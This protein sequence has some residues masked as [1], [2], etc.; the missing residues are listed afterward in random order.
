[1]SRTNNTLFAVLGLLM[2]GPCSGYDIRK[3]FNGSLRY[4][5]SES[6]GQIYPVLKDLVRAG[7]ARVEEATS[8]RQKKIYWITP[9]GE[10]VYRRWLVEPT[11]PI[12][13]RD[14]LLLKVFLGNIQERDGMIRLFQEECNVLEQQLD[15]Y[16]DNRFE[17]EQHK[18]NVS[19]PF[20][21][22]TLGYGIMSTE[23]RLQW[24][25][26][27]IA[28]LQSWKGGNEDGAI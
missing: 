2:K 26:E 21:Q 9:E 8:S 3:Q 25:R 24:C 22:L 27:A 17:V 1:M 18:E 16:E 7:Y 4:F 14:E 10:T 28:R 13:Y 5:W 20:W 12:Q 19:Y 11:N 15:L 6:Y 23:T